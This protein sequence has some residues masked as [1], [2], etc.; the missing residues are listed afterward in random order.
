VAVEHR[1][2]DLVDLFQDLERLDHGQ[3]PPELGPLAE[4]HPHGLRL[5]DAIVVRHEP[6]DFQRAAGRL[7][8][9]G[10]HFDRGGFPGAVRTDVAD[11]LARFDVEGDAC[12]CLNSPV[13]ARK[14]VAER[15][16]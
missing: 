12:H 13:V 9:A 16:A 11:D 2:I 3:V 6:V 10:H 4:D 8:D 5:A 14:Q 1:L 15:A 7:Q